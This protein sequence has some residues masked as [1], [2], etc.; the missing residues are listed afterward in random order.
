TPH[1][2]DGH[3]GL[4]LRWDS[5]GGGRWRALVTYVVELDVEERLVQEWV[6]GDLVRPASDPQEQITPAR[7]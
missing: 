3:P 2:P 4:L 5:L 7:S 1:A 6:A